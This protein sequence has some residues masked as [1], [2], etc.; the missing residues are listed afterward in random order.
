MPGS[1]TVNTPAEPKRSAVPPAKAATGVGIDRRG[2]AER[3][4][5]GRPVTTPAGD[6]KP[7]D[8]VGMV[9]RIGTR[10]AGGTIGPPVR[11]LIGEL[12]LRA[13]KMVAIA[14]MPAM[15]GRRV[16][17]RTA[18]MIGVFTGMTGPARGGRAMIGRRVEMRTA[19]MIGVLAGMI[20]AFVAMTGPARGGRAMIGRRVEPRSGGMIGV[21]VAMTGPAR[22]GRA[23][24]GR[25][26]EPRT[27]GMIG[28]LAG[29]IGALVAMTGPVRGGRAMIGRRVDLPNGEMIGRSAATAG[30]T[31]RR[32]A[33]IGALVGMSVLTIGSRSVIG[34]RVSRSTGRMIGVRAATTVV[35]SG[36]PSGRIEAGVERPVTTARHASP[37]A[38]SLIASAALHSP[39]T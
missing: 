17:L 14:P 31:V 2:P 37:G 15:I 39:G 19:G 7:R 28:V 8:V 23:M 29:M 12:A 25:R 10:A 32:R 6:L 16:E 3:H 33:M 27:G 4:L 35:A 21:L 1:V 9:I 18:G 13:A 22:G 30:V 5:S 38:P 36:P 11:M 24:I 26:V 34:H 20:G